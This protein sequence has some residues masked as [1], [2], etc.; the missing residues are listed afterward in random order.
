MNYRTMSDR[1]VASIA[2]RDPRMTTDPLFA[3]LAW[4]LGHPPGNALRDHLNGQ[5]AAPLV[6]DRVL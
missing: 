1:E 3:E 2:Y 4:R 5:R 6:T